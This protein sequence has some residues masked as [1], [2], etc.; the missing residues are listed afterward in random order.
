MISKAG[1]PLV[2]VAALDTPYGRQMR[3]LGFLAGRLKVPK[4][5]DRTTCLR[6]TTTRSIECCWRNPASKASRS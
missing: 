4:D 3:R 6:C 2:K 5:C 1:E